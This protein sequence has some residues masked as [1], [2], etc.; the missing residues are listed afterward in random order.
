M[1]YERY[2]GPGVRFD[3]TYNISWSTLSF[4]NHANTSDDILLSSVVITEYPESRH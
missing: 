2:G 1:G 3:C 4:Y